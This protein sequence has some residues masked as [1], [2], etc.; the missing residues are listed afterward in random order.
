MLSKDF[1]W[2]FSRYHSHQAL[3]NVL[4]PSPPVRL[5][6]F[7]LLVGRSHEFRVYDIILSAYSM[8]QFPY[9]SVS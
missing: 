7:N 6:T 5:R 2:N 4:V 3:F 8:T 9:G 1:V